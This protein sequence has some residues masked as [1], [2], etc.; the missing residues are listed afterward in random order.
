MPFFFCDDF[1]VHLSKSQYN[2]KSILCIDLNK[3]CYDFTCIHSGVCST[4]E[5]DGPKCECIETGYIGERCDK[6]ELSIIEKYL[7]QDSFYFSTKRF[8]F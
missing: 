6:C 7:C 5:N 4:N 2:K 8:L 1:F 3:L